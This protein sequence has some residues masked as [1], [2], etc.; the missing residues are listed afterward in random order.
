VVIGV[1]LL[2]YP[3]NDDQFGNAARVVFHG[4]GLAGS[5]A[6]ARSESI[7]D[8]ALCILDDPGFR[9]RM[10]R[11]RQHVLRF[12]RGVDFAGL[13]RD[14]QERGALVTRPGC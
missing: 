12:Q 7:R 13:V 9:D 3:R 10:L 5:R 2:V 4:V 14:A 6:T 8:Q 1:P 11:L